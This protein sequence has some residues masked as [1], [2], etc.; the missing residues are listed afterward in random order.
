MLFMQIIKEK[1]KNCKK[2]QAISEICS[3][4]FLKT[5]ISLFFYDKIT[6]YCTVLGLTRW[7]GLSVTDL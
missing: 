5:G 3:I 6:H 1:S 4:D 2:I 7:T